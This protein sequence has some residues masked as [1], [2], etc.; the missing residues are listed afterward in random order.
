MA[1]NPEI[2]NCYDPIHQAEQREAAW[3]RLIKDIPVC[4]L[5]RKQIFP[6]DKFHTA[7]CMPV[8]PSCVEE[9]N[10]NIEILE[11]T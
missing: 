9:L 7:G 11:D 2:P 3:D 1:R 6:G 8:C 5:C 10:E 4:T